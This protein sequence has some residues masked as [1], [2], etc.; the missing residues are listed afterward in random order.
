MTPRMFSEMKGKIRCL[1]NRAKQVSPIWT[2]AE[3]PPWSNQRNRDGKQ[4]YRVKY[5]YVSICQN[6]TWRHKILLTRTLTLWLF[7]RLSAGMSLLIRTIVHPDIIEIYH[8][9]R[10]DVPRKPDQN[11]PTFVRGRVKCAVVIPPP[12]ADK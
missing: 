8:P 9:R 1:P 7:V 10:R 12:T 2:R 11:K 3:G 4:N 5:I 6:D